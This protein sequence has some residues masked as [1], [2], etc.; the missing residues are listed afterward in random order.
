M[1]YC[2]FCYDNE[3]SA[4]KED[5][6]EGDLVLDR[7]RYKLYSNY[8]ISELQIQIDLLKKNKE[9]LE[10]IQESKRMIDA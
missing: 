9:D 2:E 4:H 3:H 5:E 10:R 8:L 6:E 7:A 1:V